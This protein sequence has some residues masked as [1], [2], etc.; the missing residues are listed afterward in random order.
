M[1]RPPFLNGYTT[2]WVA[3]AAEWV[4]TSNTYGTVLRGTHQGEFD[5]ALRA[6]VLHLAGELSQILHSGTWHGY[7]RPKTP[8]DPAP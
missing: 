7:P 6:H 3:K 2:A 1:S 5:D 4:A 8:A